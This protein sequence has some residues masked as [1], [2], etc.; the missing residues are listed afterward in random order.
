MI[1]PFIRRRWWLTQNRLISTV[2][3][4]LI[5]PIILHMAVNLV[6]KHIVVRTIHQ[7]AY[8]LWVYP[9]L[10][11]II[12]TV[13]LTPILYRDLFDLRVYKRSLMPMTLTPL[14]KHGIIFGILS[15]ALIES[16][17]FSVIGMA[18][19]TWIMNISFSIGQYIIIFIFV[20][21]YVALLGNVLTTFSLLTERVTM[22]I[23]ILLTFLVFL[24]FGSGLLVEFEFYPLSLGI[25]F[26]YLPTSV[27]LRHLRMILFSR[28]FDWVPLL[29]PIIVII[30]L[31][32]VNG[33]FLRRRLNQ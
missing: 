10:V 15:T 3:V 5:L 32:L 4:A 9:G 23:L 30:L 1:G 11:M 24:L 8:D 21:L 18:V 33:E 6:M 13:S 2:S 26:Q 19:L 20:F 31:S 22:F 16:M 17:L 29:Y 7:V 25:I 12:A 28:I 14:S 27:L